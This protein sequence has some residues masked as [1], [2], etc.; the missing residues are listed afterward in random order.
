MNSDRI[1]REVD[2]DENY[3]EDEEY[4]EYDTEY[5]M[6]YEEQKLNRLTIKIRVIQ[7]MGE[8]TGYYADQ[9]IKLLIAQYT[10][11]QVPGHY[12]GKLIVRLQEHFT[13]QD[14]LIAN[15]VEQLDV[16]LRWQEQDED[17]DEQ[18]DSE[19]EADDEQDDSEDED[20]DEDEDEQVH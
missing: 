13:E 1:T 12:T 6:E 4:D 17:D 16:Y 3:E 15:I 7:C 14:R 5:D 10:N 20:E 11:N 19:D 18:D 9:L 2:Y 8:I